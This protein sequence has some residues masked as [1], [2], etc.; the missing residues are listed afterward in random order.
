MCSAPGEGVEPP[1]RGSEPRVLPLNDP[2]VWRPRRESNPPHPARQAVILPRGSRGREDEAWWWW[3]AEEDLHLHS[4]LATGLQAAGL[5]D[6]RAGAFAPPR[7]CCLA[8]HAYSVVK[9]RVPDL[10]AKK[11]GPG[12]ARP[13][14]DSLI[15][16]G[17]SSHSHVGDSGPGH[18]RLR[19]C[20]RTDVLAG[21]T[22]AGMRPQPSLRLWIPNPSF[23]V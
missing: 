8:C 4:T 5:A 12:V 13:L 7:W 21:H 18:A 19:S 14:V 17:S 22:G 6:A 23:R 20:P 9:V 16:R 2:G 15:T 11:K 3:C 1:S 10:R